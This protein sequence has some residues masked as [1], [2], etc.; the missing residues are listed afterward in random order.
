MLA[1]ALYSHTISSNVSFATYAEIGCAPCRAL[2]SDFRASAAYFCPGTHALVRILGRVGRHAS[3][4]LMPVIMQLCSRHKTKSARH[5]L[6]W[7]DA[8]R[9][10]RTGDLIIFSRALSVARTTQWSDNG[11]HERRECINF[12]EKKISVTSGRPT[13]FACRT[14]QKCDACRLCCQCMVQGTHIAR[15][16]SSC[17]DW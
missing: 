6:T 10:D 16:D 12:F 4:V 9:Q 3:F 17:F 8:F 1:H 11:Y 15:D 13:W 5:C 2:E 7:I 14:W